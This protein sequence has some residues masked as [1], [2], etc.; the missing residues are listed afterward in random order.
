MDYL[1]TPWRYAYLVDADPNFPKGGR[2]GVPQALAG[3]AVS[4]EKMWTV[5]LYRRVPDA[6]VVS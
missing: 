5:P 2:K 4:G 1:W 3:K 6:I